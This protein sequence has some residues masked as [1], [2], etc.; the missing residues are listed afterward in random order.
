ML[1]TPSHLNLSQ[2][3]AAKSLPGTPYS[4]LYFYT[5]THASKIILQ[6]R[7]LRACPPTPCTCRSFS[8]GG[9]KQGDYEQLAAWVQ[10]Q[11]ATS[12]AMQAN[13]SPE[14]MRQQGMESPF[15]SMQQRASSSQISMLSAA[16]QAAAEESMRCA[17][18]CC[19]LVWCVLLLCCDLC[20]VTC[21]RSLSRGPAYQAVV[22]CC[23]TSSSA[24]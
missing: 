2:A 22:S 15:A 21:C 9:S 19:G 5:H 14:M 23:V 7:L 12:L 6:P 11:R 4:L 18:G 16:M 1:R 13:T 20:T 24:C 8:V 10:Q 17:A 3:T